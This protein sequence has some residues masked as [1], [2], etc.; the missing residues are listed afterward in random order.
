MPIQMKMVLKSKFICKMKHHILPIILSTTLLSGCSTMSS[1]RVTYFDTSIEMRLFEG[2]NDDFDNVERILSHYSK[3]SDN[4]IKYDVNNVYSIN[5]TNEEISVDKDLYDLLK[6]SYSLNPLGAYHF[7]P[8]CGSLAKKWKQALADTQILSDETIASE[9]NKIKSSNLI[10]KDNNIVQRVGGAE[11][12]LGAIAKGYCLDKVKEYLDSKQYK[13]YLIDGG[14]SSVL[15]GE[16]D[17]SDGLF[18]VRIQ[19][20]TNQYLK[21]KNCFVSTSAI[22]EQGK[23]IDGIT[24]SHIINPDNGSAVSKYDRII[25][26]SNDG[27][28]GDA[29]STSLMMADIAEIKEVEQKCSVQVLAIKD[30][31]ILYKNNSLEVFE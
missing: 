20:E 28:L 4:Y 25:V 29:L 23:T 15:L 8:L 5:Q 13:H 16:K 21:L 24:Y 31:N 7:N 18:N 3:L 10:F 9:L 17:S 12:D 6:V 22:D 1:R 11:I 19:K 2:N 26:I 27:Y 14:R 30:K